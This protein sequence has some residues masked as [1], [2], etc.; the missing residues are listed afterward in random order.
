MS[1]FLHAGG[2]VGIR[3]KKIIGIFD[4][5]TT[6][7]RKTTRD[8]LRQSETDGR[9]VGIGNEIPQTFLLTEQ[10]VYLSALSPGTLKDRLSRKDR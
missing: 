4:L 6:T 9:V 2:G 3:S 8:F 10:T 7:V 1:I 5:D